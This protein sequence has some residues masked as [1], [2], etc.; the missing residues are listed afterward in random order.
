MS[1]PVHLSPGLKKTVTIIVEVDQD[2]SGLYAVNNKNMASG[3]CAPRVVQMMDLN[4]RCPTNKIKIT[5]E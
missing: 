1:E 4:I 2:Y 3:M 5:M